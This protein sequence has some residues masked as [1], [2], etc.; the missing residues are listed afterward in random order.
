M[1]KRGPRCVLITYDE[2]GQQIETCTVD[3]DMVAALKER[4]LVMPWSLEDRLFTLDDE[5]AGQLGGL[6]GISCLRHNMLPRR[7]HASQTENPAGGPAGDS[8]RAA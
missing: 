3:R 7:M 6:S 5:F 4:A 8:R 2:E 1:S